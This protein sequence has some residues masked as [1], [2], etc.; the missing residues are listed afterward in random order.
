MAHN[1]KQADFR[2]L[3][4]CFI[5][6]F[7]S[8]QVQADD[9][10]SG[11][12]SQLRALAKHDAVLSLTQEHDGQ[13]EFDELIE[14]DETW[15]QLP[16]KRN[17]FLNAE[18]QQRFK[19]MLK[20]NNSV[21]VGLLLLGSQGETLAAYPLPSD[22]WHGNTAKFVNVMADENIFVDNLSWDKH[23]RQIKAN[24]SVPIKDQ[25]GEMF[26]V[27]SAQVDTQ[28]TTSLSNISQ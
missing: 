20:E 26:G 3:A 2:A 25:N 13:L 28:I 27:L 18:M 15:D 24:V 21:F 1:L 10:L 16:A 19:L 11:P 5:S 8:V 4:Y 23:S 17:A 9:A 7:V 14:H 12:L 6:L 22:Y